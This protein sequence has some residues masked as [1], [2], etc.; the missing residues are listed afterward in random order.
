[1][2]ALLQDLRYAARLLARQPGFTLVAV[3]TLALGI[4][5]N[6]ALF[7]V[8]DHVL[9]RALPYEEP[10]R[11]VKVWHNNAK[12]GIERDPLSYPTFLDLRARS[13]AVQPLAAISPLWNL[14]LATKTGP[15]R[16]PGYFVSPNFFSLL[17]VEAEHG[18]LFIPEED[19]PGVEPIV[20]LSHRFWQRHFG[21]DPGVI[22]QTL[23]L[24]HSSTVIG[25]LPADFRFGKDVDV[26]LPLPLNPILDRGRAVR[27]L[28]VVGRLA[29][30]A[31]REQGRAELS[32][33]ARQLEQQYPDTNTGLGFNLVPLH[34]D[35]VRE[36]RPALLFLLGGVGF[37]LLIACVNVANLLLNR[38]VARRREIAIRQALGASRRRIVAQLLTES[39]CLGLLGGAAGALLAVWGVDL[40]LA[41]SPANV[42]R[43]EEI[44]V[45]AR[46]LAFTFLLSLVTGALAGLVP[47]W[48]ASGLNLLGVLKESG[49]THSRR[50]QRSQH[51]LAVLEMAL[52]LVSLV[53]AGLM[54][55]SF[56]RV[57]AV[58][59]G[60]R[61]DHVLTLQISTEV[62]EPAR[63]VAFYQELFQRI[64][65]LP[66]VEAVG[67]STRIPL[68]EGVTTALEIYGRP[69]PEG[70]RP[71]VE[72]RRASADYF[73]AMG[74]P[75]LR[76][77]FFTTDDN[78]D[79]PRVVL[80]NQTAA[81][82]FWPNQDPV[83][84]QIRFGPDPNTPWWTIV[85]VVGDVKHFG[86]DSDPRPELYMTI[87]QGPPLGP[88][89]AIRASGDPLS[90][91]PA[92]REQLRALDPESV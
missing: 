71:E 69:V 18:R 27:F 56:V 22:G 23:N 32:A 57:L 72:F 3:L 24:G 86:L 35:I 37:V 19:H 92:V 75:L 2:G 77:R 54:I 20:V 81:R 61:R 83:G 74:I 8:A 85:G 29:P 4:G 89:L 7:T 49:V 25:V 46:I 87:D 79:A 13:A 33:L 43:L 48:Q 47:A 55:R 91:V 5:A 1:M 42:P 26:F 36:V 38:A 66:G 30:G 12:E 64:E 53:G 63:R 41:L 70:E 73:R 28:E 88:F 31:S 65:K 67:V 76:G 80:I 62:P 15:E 90:L 40:L 11:L 82:R 6:T 84:Q 21:S 9:L 58:D 50:G 17:G 14:V 59:P 34:E 39:L 45:D 60:F 44:R 52:A 51:A 78:L 16:I 68:R 10:E